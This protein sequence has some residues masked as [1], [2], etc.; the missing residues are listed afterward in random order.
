M[1]RPTDGHCEEERRSNP[2]K[3]GVTQRI[4]A[5]GVRKE[6]EEQIA[7]VMLPSQ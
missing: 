5:Y 2:M 4:T 3:G 1:C 6:R 7:S